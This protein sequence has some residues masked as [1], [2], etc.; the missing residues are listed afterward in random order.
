[1]AE[2]KRAG[3][4]EFLR[5]KGVPYDG[6]EPRRRAAV[7]AGAR[8]GGSRRGTSSIPASRQK[9]LYAR[10][11]ESYREGAGL[12][13]WVDLAQGKTPLPGARYFSAEQKQVGNQTVA[14]ATLGFDGPR[15]GLAAQLAAPSPMGS[16]DYISPDA[17]A[18]LGFVVKDPGAIVDAAMAVSQGSMAAAQQTLADERQQKGFNVRDDLAASLG[19]EF[20]VAMDGSLMPVPS[21]KLVSEVYDPD[22]LQ[23]T[24]QRFVD[25]HNREAAPAG[26][27]LIRTAQET[28]DGRTYY[29]IALADSGPLMEAHYTFDQGYLVAAPTRA[30]VSRALQMKLAGTSIKHSGKFL[31]LTPRD[32]HV[33]FSAL[34]Y[35]NIGTSIAPLASMASAFLQQ[36]DGGQNGS[37]L[38]SLNN[39]KPT[40]FAVYGETDRITMAA[41]GDVLGSTLENLLGGDLRGVTFAGLPFGQ[42]VGTHAPRTAYPGR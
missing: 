41:T 29:T 4:E 27:K 42:M 28:V 7:R 14:S 9:P 5:K 30:L 2:Q 10:I 15:T 33:N 24:L 16:L 1:M 25:A 40:L 11:A 32:Q 20:A 8:R 34:I 38:Q 23:A 31:E 26:K 12:M 39:V 3:F 22:R 17:L 36:R 13:L 6:G 37:S 19:G 21:W 18:V 35:Q